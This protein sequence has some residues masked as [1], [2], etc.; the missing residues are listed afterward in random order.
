MEAEIQPK[1]VKPKQSGGQTPPVS[2]AAKFGGQTA[3]AAAKSGGQTAPA[4][5]K[6]GGQTV[7]AEATS[8]PPGWCSAPEF[9]CFP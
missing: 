4:A 5:A 6:S 3:P 9:I 2:A 7:P 8:K 1:E